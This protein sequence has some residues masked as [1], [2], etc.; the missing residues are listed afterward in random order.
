MQFTAETIFGLTLLF[1][2]V[3]ILIVYRNKRSKTKGQSRISAVLN[4]N[5][6]DER[7]RELEEKYNLKEES[8]GFIQK[9]EKKLASGYSGITLPIYIVILVA[10]MLVWF[11]LGAFILGNPALGIF[12]SFVGI[13]IPRQVVESREIKN[14][15]KFNERLV[16]ALRQ[17]ASSLRTGMTQQQA[18][19]DI[20][21]SEMIDA[22]IREEFRHVLEDIQTNTTVGD[23]FMLMYNRTNSPEILDLAVAIGTQQEFGGKQ[24]ELVE[25]ISKN[26]LAKSVIDSEVR[27]L[28]GDAESTVKIFDFAPFAMVILLYLMSPNFFDPLFANFGMRMLA[29]VLVIFMYIGGFF[30]RKTIRNLM[31]G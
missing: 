31:R 25:I 1:F 9:L 18:L 20:V 22:K 12:T 30:I 11:G 7:I 27:A 26:I 3:I 28:M 4:N 17:M 19:E 15:A 5:G 6:L 14:K 8:L 13:L 21:A 29:M 10:S 2:L 24:S 16:R 23:A